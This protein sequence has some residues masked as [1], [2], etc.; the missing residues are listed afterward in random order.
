MIFQNHVAMR[1][2][3]VLS[4]KSL[5]AILGIAISLFSFSQNATAVSVNFS[6]IEMALANPEN[7]ADDATF[8]QKQQGMN[9]LW[10]DWQTQMFEYN[11][12]F[13]EIANGSD[14]TLSISEF[15]MTIGDTD[16]QFSN[17]FKH[18]NKT[19]SFPF[20]ANG[21]YAIA[22][23]STPDIP[24]TS[25]IEN[26][27]DVL[28]LNFGNGGL[29]PGEVVRFQVDINADDLGLGMMSFAPYTEIFFNKDGVPGVIDPNNSI[30]AFEFVEDVAGISAQLPNY[31]VI[32]AVDVEDPRDHADMQMI[33]LL[34]PLDLTGE[35]PEPTSL[36]LLG[37]AGLGAACCRRRRNR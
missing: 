23:Y 19:N 9:A 34:P 30:V 6:S 3:K 11:M 25:S 31:Q 7:F 29:K 21:E 13:I 16:Y 26:G 8:D 33:D 14:Q 12:P 35:I 20:A 37:I 32:H 36:T 27:G 5:L 10:V 4:C 24:F 17:E 2:A 18:K 15:R 22:G 28:V 1:Q